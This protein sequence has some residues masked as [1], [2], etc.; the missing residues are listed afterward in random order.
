MSDERMQK[1][2]IE[3]FCKPPPRDFSDLEAWRA[4]RDDT[5]SLLQ[6]LDKLMEEADKTELA[7]LQAR[8]ASLQSR[9]GAQPPPPAPPSKPKPH[10][11]VDETDWGMG[12]GGR[13]RPID[14]TNF[15]NE[16]ADLRDRTTEKRA[17]RGVS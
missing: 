16:L 14:P 12:V 2:L 13:E 4:F 9:L 11:P 10:N 7:R 1:I 17:R 5:Y 6:Q 8:M 15:R 3:G